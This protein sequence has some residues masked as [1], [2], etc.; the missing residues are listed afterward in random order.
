MKFGQ[1]IEYNLINIFLQKSYRKWGRET[2]VEIYNTVVHSALF[3]GHLVYTCILVTLI[4][5]NDN[6]V[7]MRRE[8][9][10]IN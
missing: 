8:L 10:S 1:L 7:I 5:R 4:F 3:T 2:F 6:A 9:T